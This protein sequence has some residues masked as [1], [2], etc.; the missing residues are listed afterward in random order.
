MTQATVPFPP[1]ALSC[2]ANGPDTVLVTWQ[3]PAD[4]GSSISAY[5]LHRGDGEG[6]DFQPVYNGGDCEYQSTG[7][8]SGLQYRF[9]VLAEN[10]VGVMHIP[11]CCNWN[12]GSRHQ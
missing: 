4:G 2:T 7:L 1:E 12:V 8:R 10:E 9:R 6:G 3:A 5:Q 11:M